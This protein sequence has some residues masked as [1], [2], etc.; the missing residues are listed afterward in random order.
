MR[1][2]LNDHDPGLSHDRP[3]VFP[4]FGILSESFH[5]EQKKLPLADSGKREFPGTLTPGNS[6]DLGSR[7]DGLPRPHTGVSPLLLRSQHA[8]SRGTSSV[9]LAFGT[10]RLWLEVS[11]ARMRH[12]TRPRNLRGFY[13]QLEEWILA[14]RGATHVHSTGGAVRRTGSGV[15]GVTGQGHCVW[16]GHHPGISTSQMRGC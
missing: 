15:K 4:G 1:C 7:P 12:R 3:A 5:L 6:G 8:K 11:L 16:P 14:D 13:H 9:G 2:L 10:G